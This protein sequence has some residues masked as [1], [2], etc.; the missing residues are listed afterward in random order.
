LILKKRSILSNG[1]TFKNVLKL[2]TFVLNYDNGSHLYNNITS[3]VLNNGFATRHFN[4][5][6]GVRQGCPLSVIM[7]FIG[8]VILSN[9]VNRLR[10]IEGNQIDPNNYIKITQYA[11]DTTFFG[12]SI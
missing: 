6:R 5:S 11:D 12:A 9:A 1:A 4:L 8:V 3:C 7:F 10:E 2:S